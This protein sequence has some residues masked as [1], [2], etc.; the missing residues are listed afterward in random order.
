MQIWVTLEVLQT[1]VALIVNF[2][3]DVGSCMNF[4]NAFVQ[5][6][7]HAQSF[8]NAFVQC[9]CTTT[10]QLTFVGEKPPLSL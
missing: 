10:P 5:V 8:N 3:C 7:F 1:D 4:N 2:F 6:W 9:N